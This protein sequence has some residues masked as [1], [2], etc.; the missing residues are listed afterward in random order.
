[1]KYK[2]V[3]TQHFHMHTCVEY[4]SF[5]RLKKYCYVEQLTLLTQPA[6][7]CLKEENKICYFIVLNTWTEREFF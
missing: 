6:V 3:L 7:L 1:M 2:H 5:L 4:I